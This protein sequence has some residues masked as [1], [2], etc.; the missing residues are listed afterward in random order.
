MH[1][2]DPF[3]L[4]MSLVFAGAVF[5][6]HSITPYNG[7]DRQRQW[8]TRISCQRGIGMGSQ[9]SLTSGI[10]RRQIESDRGQ[11]P[12]TAGAVVGN[13]MG[14]DYD[15]QERVTRDGDQRARNV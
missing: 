15:D 13:D 9:F 14:R 6:L 1:R 11:E 3:T 10:L 7:L 4:W 8:F 5:G 2:H 12:A